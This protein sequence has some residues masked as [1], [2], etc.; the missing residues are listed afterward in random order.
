[1]SRKTIIAGNWKMNK[2][3][4]E[5]RELAREL[6]A[7]VDKLSEKELPH[8]VLCPTFTSLPAVTTTLTGNKK[9]ATGAQN[10]D[11]RDSGAFTGEISAP[12][13]LDL[14]AQ[15]V[16][17]G[18]SERRQFFGETDLSV[19]QKLKAA[20]KHKLIPI[21]CVGESLDEREEISQTKW[22]PNRS[23]AL[24]KTSSNQS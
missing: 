12:M 20:L 18:H 6:I 23:L 11:Y 13:L 14:G 21:V 5:A 17:I 3:A 19:N 24:C 2:T 1:M 4:T 15:Y 22:L 10:M 9:F 16:L 8:I 7:A